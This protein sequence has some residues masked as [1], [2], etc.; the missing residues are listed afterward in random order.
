MIIKN[1]SE[2]DALPKSFPV[3][4][5]I[6]I[7]CEGWL[8]INSNPENSNVVARENS[9]VVAWENSNVEAW[10]NSN[11]VAWGNSNV[12]ARGNSN[13]VAWENSNVVARENSNVVAW[14]SV[15]IHAHSEFSTIVLMAFAVCIALA[16]CKITK[17]SET[18]T[19]VQP[20]FPKGN[21]GWLE[22]EGVEPTGSTILL[23]KRVSKDFKTQEGTDRETLWLVGSTV[24]HPKWSP[25]DEE[26]GSGKFHGCSRPYFAD[27]FRSERGDR[28]I[29]IEVDLK[30]IHAWDE[31]QYPHKIAFRQGKVLFECNKFG[32]QVTA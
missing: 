26:C 15:S 5:V 14:G 2:W 4:T 7:R 21:K 11:V 32:K 19:I 22:N 30:D 16:K 6:E 13:V 23:F 29:A 9:N 18:A 10:G 28:Y 31:A 3:Y 20:K 24:T 27:Q 17:K 8:Y 25:K 12:V 1:Q